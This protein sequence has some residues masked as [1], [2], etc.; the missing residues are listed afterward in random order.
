MVVAIAESNSI[1]GNSTRINS[2]TIVNNINYGQ[3]PRRRGAG[4]GPHSRNSHTQREVPDLRSARSNPPSTPRPHFSPY[5]DLRDV[6]ALNYPQQS[7]PSGSSLDQA[8][9]DN[10]WVHIPRPPTP[11]PAALYHNATVEDDDESSNL[12]RRGGG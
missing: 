4:R 10:R 3:P 8:R 2:P 12:G 7:E 9:H 5:S 11:S 6:R 1:Q